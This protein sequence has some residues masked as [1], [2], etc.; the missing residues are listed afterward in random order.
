MSSL[1]TCL[2]K[3]MIRLRM[4]PEK[5]WAIDQQTDGRKK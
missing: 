3:T 4:V 1:Y 2:P 5:S